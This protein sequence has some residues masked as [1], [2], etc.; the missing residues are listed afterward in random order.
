MGGPQTRIVVLS[1]NWKSYVPMS[2]RKTPAILIEVND[3]F[4]LLTVFL[5]YGERLS[6]A[7]LARRFTSLARL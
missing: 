5:A 7:T 1:Q 3:E 6:T 4:E 2:A